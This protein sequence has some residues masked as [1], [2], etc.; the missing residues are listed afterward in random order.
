MSSRSFLASRGSTPNRVNGKPLY[1]KKTFTSLQFI[2][3][4]ALRLS[5]CVTG[6]EGRPVSC[7][8]H[9]T[10]LVAICRLLTAEAAVKLQGDPL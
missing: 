10:D 7:Y 9:L 2:P 8:Q 1:T 6:E 5:V 4:L 3:N